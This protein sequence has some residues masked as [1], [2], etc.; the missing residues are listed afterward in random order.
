M[1][2]HF[3]V[4]PAHID[5]TYPTGLSGAEIPEYLAT[6]KAMALSEYHAAGTVVLTADT[7]VWHQGMVLEK[8]PG[9]AA[10]RETLRQ[11]SGTW[12]EVF[13]SVCFSGKGFLEVKHACTE[14]K[15]SALDDTLIETYLRK[16]HPL[17][18]A[19]AYGIQEWI[20]LVGVEEI[21]GSYT[22]VVGMPTQVVYKTLRDMAGRYF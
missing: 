11:L 14:V 13:T 12:H 1:G 17:D 18:K 15:F 9:V 3:E 2:L 7:I 20:G 22:N 16:G 8:P 4:H 19:G 6:R 21:R 10:A 5:E